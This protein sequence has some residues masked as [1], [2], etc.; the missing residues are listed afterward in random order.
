MVTAPATVLTLTG[1]VTGY[2][3]VVTGYI[4]VV[5]GYIGPPPSG[6]V[7]ALHTRDSEAR[8]PTAGRNGPVMASCFDAVRRPASPPGCDSLQAAPRPDWA[9]SSSRSSSIGPL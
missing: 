6:T 4:R 7:T 2:I 5:T 1:Y 8:S 3:R 9:T